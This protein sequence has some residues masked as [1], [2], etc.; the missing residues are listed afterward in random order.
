MLHTFS[1]SV[2]SD[3]LKVTVEISVERYCLWQVALDLD[4]WYVFQLQLEVE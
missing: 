3:C 2:L 4:I 1:W